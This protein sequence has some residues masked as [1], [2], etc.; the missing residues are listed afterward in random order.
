M[1]FK[2]IE[3]DVGWTF[4]EIGENLNLTTKKEEIWKKNYNN[5]HKTSH[6]SIW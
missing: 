3:Y 4:K 6:F 5:G 2:P 1:H